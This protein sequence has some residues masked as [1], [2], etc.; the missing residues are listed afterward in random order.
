V[1]P[2]FQLLLVFVLAMVMI[3][4]AIFCKEYYKIN[5]ATTGLVLTD[6]A[7]LTDKSGK[8]VKQDG[9]GFKGFPRI[10][11][12][13][14]VEALQ[15]GLADVPARG[16]CNLTLLNADEI[17]MN[18]DRWQFSL[19]WFSALADVTAGDLQYIRQDIVNEAFNRQ[20]L[21][22]PYPEGS[23]LCDGTI[24]KLFGSVASSY[25][26]F[27]LYMLA[28]KKARPPRGGPQHIVTYDLGGDSTTI[29]WNELENAAQNAAGELKPTHKYRLLW[30]AFDSQAVADGEA[31]MARVTVPGWP[32]LTFVGGGT[33][34]NSVG[35][36]RIWFV[37]DSIEMDGD[38][39]HKVEGHIGVANQPLVHLCWEDMGKK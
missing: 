20:K 30:G 35:I 5:N 32:P 27:V 36:R 2:T 23:T 22:M 11:A 24:S 16:F 39:V 8:A 33:I 31:L 1:R 25:S 10:H 34:F 28:G 17:D 37:D 21:N 3:S 7:F 14:G 4:M 13:S 29:V 19:P 12:A 38:S 18:F 6:A 26:A 15:A 9:A